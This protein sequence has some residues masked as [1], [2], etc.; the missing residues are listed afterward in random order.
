MSK[1]CCIGIIFISAALN[2]TSSYAN[3]IKTKEQSQDK[4]SIMMLWSRT[5]NIYI[6]LSAGGSYSLETSINASPIFWDPSPEG[7]NSDLGNSEVLGAS[8]GYVINPLFRFELGADHRDSFKYKKYQS[9]PT[10]TSWGPRNRYFDLSNTTV[11]GTLFLDGSGVSDRFFYQGKG[12]IIDPFFGVGLGA[13][14][15]TLDNLHS[16]SL[17]KDMAGRAFSL[18]ESAYTSKA[19]AYQLNAGVTIKTT[20]KIAIGL[21]YRYLDAGHFES[22]NYLVDNPDNIGM[23]SGV[24]VPTWGGSLKTN[25]FYVTIKYA[26]NS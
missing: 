22:N 9:T 7:Y 1:K 13:A 19:F 8:I 15:N 25:E 20:R 24:T 5:G 4:D 11:M 12:F 16:V 23:T 21:G 18:M 17:K 14:F 6:A 10:S 2:L 3:K 26:I